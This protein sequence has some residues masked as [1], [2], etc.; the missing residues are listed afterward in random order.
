MVDKSSDFNER[1]MDVF[2]LDRNERTRFAQRQD[3]VLAGVKNPFIIPDR[4]GVRD[5]DV[6][7]LNGGHLLVMI[8]NAKWIAQRQIFSSLLKTLQNQNSVDDLNQQGRQV[9]PQ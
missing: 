6:R 1:V 7:M 3:G 8:T 2:H 9:L 5:Y 4:S